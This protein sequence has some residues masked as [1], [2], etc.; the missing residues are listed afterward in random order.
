MRMFLS[1]ILC[2]VLS[3]YLNQY[4]AIWN[5]VTSLNS[6]QMFG[7]FG[8]TLNWKLNFNFKFTFQQ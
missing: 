8:F 1:T 4:K 3:Q 6:L 5:L 7:S 2:F